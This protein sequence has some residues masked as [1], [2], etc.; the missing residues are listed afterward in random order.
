[1]KSFE[2]NSGKLKKFI[3]SLIDEEDDYGFRF[4]EL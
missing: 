3:D 4:T 2:D 1:V